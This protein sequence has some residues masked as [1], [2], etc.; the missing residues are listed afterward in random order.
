MHIFRSLVATL[1]VACASTG[2]AAAAGPEAYA[3]R[4]ARIVPVSGPV[5]EQ[6]TVVIAH[7]V[8]TAIGKDVA[9]PPDAWVI[10]GKG[11]TVYPGLI[12][13]LTDLG[14]AQPA[15]A[16]PGGGGPGGGGPGRPGG[17]APRPPAARGPEDRPSTTPWVQ[18]ADDIKTDDR[19]FESW[20][21][22]GFTTALSAP[23]TGIF[24]GQGAVINLAGERAGDLVLLSPASVQLSFQ[25]PGGF[26]GF[27]G[28]LMGVVAYIRQV[29]SDVN[30]DVEA[31]KV[32][33]A[34]P[35]GVERPAYDRTVRTL[36]DAQA[37]GRPV[38]MPATTPVQIARALSL[39]QEL[40]LKPVLV[41]LTQGYRAADRL[42]AAKTPAIVSLKWPEKDANADPDGDE[43]L[44]SLR[45]RTLAPSTPAAFSKAGVKFA[46][47]SD[48]VQPQNLLKN[49]RKAIDAGLPADAALKALTLDAADILGVSN[50]VGSLET[51]KV[52]NLVVTDGD[53]FAEKTKI[54]M[55]FVDGHKFDIKEAAA[56]PAGA[57]GG[58]GA[59]TAG[60]A[61]LAGR[62]TF[63]ITTPEG[64]ESPTLSAT[65]GTD[66]A[67]TGSMTGKRGTSPITT[68]T[69]TG[70]Q[71]TFTISVTTAQGTIPVT[72]SGTVD[73][74]AVKGTMSTD[75]FSTEFTG[76][77]GPTA[78]D[79]EESGLDEEMLDH[80]HPHHGQRARFR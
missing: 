59:P 54:K 77:R 28:S 56:R 58:R 19:R 20:R 16:A 69:M 3:I 62:W 29:Y 31:R 73:G 57:D 55:T 40:K 48:G 32:Y 1:A 37:A 27:P 71:F 13:A 39:A 2:V 61:S 10:D 18:A 49:V 45:V 66:G 38:F 8:I 67:I 23:K 9:V 25:P 21:S 36:A 80:G 52:A 60:G 34:N 70:A 17:D 76:T 33:D 53:L 79:A 68:G 24:P 51:G 5:I 78:S 7:G 64:A 44:R 50:R 4:Q 72:F 30:Y 42:A 43:L 41:G 63:A 14:L 74:G 12:D 11:L 75:G 47:T 15:A 65:V 6:G 22:A 46:F 35:R 26:V